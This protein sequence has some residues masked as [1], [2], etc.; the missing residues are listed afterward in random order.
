MILVKCEIF[1][2]G[3]LWLAHFQKRLHTFYHKL[4]H[5][6]TQL[7]VFNLQLA[8]EIANGAKDTLRG[9]QHNKPLNLEVYKEDRD[10]APDNCTG[11]M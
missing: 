3:A 1:L 2:V 6:A 5:L 10:V 4:T 9:V 7:F 8:D 11:I